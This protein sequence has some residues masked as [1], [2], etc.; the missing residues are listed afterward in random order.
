MISLKQRGRAGLQ[1][2]GS[3]QHYS[4]SA[5][6]DQAEAEF[7]RQPE[8]AA[9]TSEFREDVRPTQWRERLDRAR[10]VAERSRAYRYNRFYQRWVAEQNFARAI[11]AVEA[12]RQIWLD[13]AARHAP[14][15]TSRLILDPSLGMPDWYAGIEWHLEPGGW[16]SYD[17]AQP[18]FAAG[19]GPY[20]FALGGYAAVD[21]DGDIRAQ[22][23]NVLR[24]FRNQNP[25][26]VYEP[27]CGGANTLGVARGL[28]PQA[29]LIG[30]DLSAALLRNG[31]FASEMLGLKILFRQEDACKVAEQN[32]SVDA[33][34]SYALHHEMP[35]AVSKRVLQEMWRILAPGGEI[36]IN[37]PPPFRGV[38]PLQAVILD[39]DTDNR[40]EP[41]F[42]AAAMTN[43]AQ[44]LREIGFADV[45]EYSL[46]KRGYPWVTR[47]RKPS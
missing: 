1:F 38:S 12:R 20:V 15:D 5:L 26:R 36:V 37:D 21:V 39:W 25:K 35:P 40:A 43:L 6:R 23:G 22:R 17:L 2:L 7:A 41:Y 4:G 32:A 9:L 24:Q 18:M 30:G 45:E 46:E 28:W 47:G 29:Q 10:D 27:G 8:C 31:H 42:S 3:L 33:V 19:I 34:I 14:K 11:P 44:M 16:D 13:F